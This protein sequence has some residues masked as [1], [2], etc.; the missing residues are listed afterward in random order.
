M[1][2]N[3]DILY[4]PCMIF[5]N[6]TSLPL[7]LLSSLGDNGTLEP[8]VGKGDST[9]DVLDRGKVSWWLVGCGTRADGTGVLA[10][11]RSGLQSDSVSFSLKEVDPLANEPDS[12]LVPVSNFGCMMSDKRSATRQQ[13]RFRG[14]QPAGIEISLQSLGM[15]ARRVSARGSQIAHAQAS[16]DHTP[17]T[18]HLYQLPKHPA[19]RSRS[20]NL[21][22]SAP[23][24]GRGE[25]GQECAVCRI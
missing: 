15:D 19:I 21:A 10:D 8:L 9:S 1:P 14:R 2:L 18:I 12:P 25:T 7:L 13:L 11:S 20:R 5:N 23:N 16:L 6:V 22:P 4:S 3:A 24:P 17:R